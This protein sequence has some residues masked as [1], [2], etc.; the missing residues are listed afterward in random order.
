MPVRRGGEDEVKRCQ[1]DG[2]SNE[3]GQHFCEC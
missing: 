3:N 1:G 2:E